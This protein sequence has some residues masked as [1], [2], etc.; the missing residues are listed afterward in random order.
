MEKTLAVPL[1]EVVI[2]SYPESLHAI[3]SVKQESSG[4]SSTTLQKPDYITERTYTWNQPLKPDSKGKGNVMYRWSAFR[5]F[6]R[7]PMIIRYFIYSVS[8]ALILMIPG[9]ISYTK[10][11]KK[12]E[13][14]LRMEERFD[15]NG[16]E[17]EY[18]PEEIKLE[19]M[20]APLYMWSI[21]F[22]T[23]WVSWFALLWAYTSLPLLM[24][25][26]LNLKNKS[27]SSI[28]SGTKIN[29]WIEHLK[30]MQF[31]LAFLT[32]TLFGWVL[33][34]YIFK[35]HETS[36]IWMREH[37]DYVNRFWM[38]LFI[39]ATT[40]A[41]EKLVL[42]VFSFHFHRVTIEIHLF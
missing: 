7:S 5:L 35:T 22:S 16:I 10:Y 4:V 31:Y 39:F 13:F 36:Q 34:D 21:F 18:K 17:I 26:I 42:S 25:R 19:I 24:T 30:A 37:L 9:I 12:E 20:G 41:I 27:V 6:N 3:K 14:K 28:D 2:D 1:K 11:Q 33:W 15:V 23:L 8:G 32:W 40:W 29:Y 38:T